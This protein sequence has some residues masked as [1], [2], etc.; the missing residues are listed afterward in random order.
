MMSTAPAAGFRSLGQPVARRVVTQAAVRGLLGRTFLVHGPPGAG[1]DAFVDDLLA[2]VFCSAEPAQRPCNACRGCR[3]ARARSHP[4]LVIGSPERWREQRTTGESIVAA[5]RRWLLDAAGAPVVADRRVVVVEHADAASDHIQNALLKVLEEPTGR[6]TFVLVADDPARL[7]P[8]IRSRSQPLRI[9]P[10]ARDELVAH[11]VDAERLP[12]DQAEAL[13]RI[14]GGLSGSAVGFAHDK[15]RLAWRRQT[16]LRLLGLLDAGRGERF[17]AVR[18][19]ID[20]AVGLAGAMTDATPED[21]GTRTPAGAQR[22]AAL[23]VVDAWLA[24][25]RDLLVSAA[26]RPELAPGAELGEGIP[27]AARRL[28]VADLASML[29][30][31]ERVHAGLR[32]NAAPR[33]SLEVAMLAWPSPR[34]AAG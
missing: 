3:D 10:V 18:D 31:L 6:H 5:A 30:T 13:A 29:A 32:E 20:D 16:Q 26:G 2:L 1:K 23:L 25:S 7:L 24:L 34:P 33:L 28:E 17:A 9:G 19:L 27:E 14:S 12:L 4:D 8:T 15:H 11:L 21:E 22:E